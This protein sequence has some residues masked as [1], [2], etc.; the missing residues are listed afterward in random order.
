MTIGT[1]LPR[2]DGFAK[3]TG[4]ALY[5]ADHRA[6]GML[7]GA[8]V[9]APLPAGRVT[10]I[11]ASA[12]LDVPGVVHV[13]TQADMPRLGPAPS[14]PLATV[15]LPMQGDEIRHEGQP[16]AIVLAETPEAARH[17]AGL[18]VADY[19]PALFEMPAEGAD[20]RR[21][22]P[23]AADSGHGFLPPL[24]EKGDARAAVAGSVHRIEASY[25][26]PCRHHNPMETS[27]TL[28]EWDGDRL[29]LHDA[30]QGGFAVR[31]V[32][33]MLFGLKEEDVRVVCPHTGG[34]FGCKGYVWPHQFLAAQAA[35]VAGRPVRIA[36]TRP[37]MYAM[38]GYQPRI[39]Q[40][41]ALG[42]DAQGRLLGIVH[43][44]V[45][46]TG[47]TDD[48]QEPAF[49]ASRALYASP[50]I[51]TSL[52]VER[53]HVNQPTPMRA[54]VEGPGTWALESAMNELAHALGMDPLDLRLLNHADTDPADGK[55]W[56]SKKLRE[57][58]EEGAAMFGWRDRPREPVRDGPWLVGTGMATCTMGAFRMPSTARLRL[59]ADG[60][61][62]VESGFHD[63]G[64]GTL[65]IFP[66]IA[67]DVLGLDPSRVS[68]RMGDTALPA[69]AMT[70]GSS[71]TLGVGSAVLNAAEEIRSKLARLANLPPGEVEM[72]GG[73]IAR[74]GSVDAIP[75][76]D[77]MREAGLEE[78]EAMGAFS[79]P[80]DAQMNIDGADTA[81]SIRTFGAV[82]VEVGVDPELGLLR[83]RRAMGSY[84]AGRIINPRTA[85]SQ[86]IG[87]IV[88]GWG[89][90]AMEESRHDPRLGRWLSKNLSGVAIPVNAD[91]PADIRIHFVDEFDAHASPLGAKGIGELGATGVA[92]AVADAVFQATGRRIREL[93]ITP[94]KLV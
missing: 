85:R 35:R 44:S 80:G 8:F 58:Y 94:E 55:P 59:S 25:V 47:I 51:A 16:V 73:A 69:A 63:I 68:A 6:N 32:M 81:Y 61:A 42:A 12:A 70:A 17:G 30:V 15:F 86:M 1:S 66:Q 87:G 31:A 26:Q 82:F 60:S 88:W 67:A 90:A 50:A 37:Q 28:A 72:R 92:A 78:V 24:F 19:A 20:T 45:N 65:T 3:V 14:P 57:A 49:Q 56:S 9:Q 22:V 84:S 89:K 29:T 77:V 53:S 40:H 18:V 11:D 13:L 2:P 79:L 34:G 41:M 7:H 93:P 46:V 36:L 75:I 23:P 64:T 83:L 71:S 54:P 10:A 91:I 5:A 43:D 27:A 74:R 4:V 52:K 62:V 38:V 33:A 39:V 76:A 21:A 48:F